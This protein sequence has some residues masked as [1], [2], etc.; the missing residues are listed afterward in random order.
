[1]TIIGTLKPNPNP[2]VA[3]GPTTA[4]VAILVRVPEALTA[5]TLVPAARVTPPQS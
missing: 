4:C 5:L 3:Q 2:L 1:M